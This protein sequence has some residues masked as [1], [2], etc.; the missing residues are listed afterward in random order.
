MSWLGHADLVQP[1]GEQVL[2]HLSEFPLP[3]AKQVPWVGCMQ[4]QTSDLECIQQSYTCIPEMQV[5]GGR[6]DAGL[7]HE[8]NKQSVSKM[9]L[10]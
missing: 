5:C 4:M 2:L 3:A 6:V 8:D 1:S 10:Q 7:M 9:H